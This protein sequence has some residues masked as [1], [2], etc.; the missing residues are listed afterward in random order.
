MTEQTIIKIEAMI[1]YLETHLN[2]KLSLDTV[3]T[4]VHYSKY[5]LSRFFSIPLAYT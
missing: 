1:E 3:A 4:A 5:H 2:E